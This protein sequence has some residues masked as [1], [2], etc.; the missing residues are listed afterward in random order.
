VL[1]KEHDF[2]R[3]GFGER[4]IL[5]CDQCEREFHVGCLRQQHGCDLQVRLGRR[6]GRLAVGVAGWGWG[7][8]PCCDGVEVG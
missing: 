5:I 3:G 7:W 4:T 6:G 8:Q 1:C 2:Q